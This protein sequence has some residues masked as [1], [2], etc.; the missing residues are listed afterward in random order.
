VTNSITPERPALHSTP[1]HA[2]LGELGRRI[3]RHFLLKTVGITGFMW[4]FFVAYFYLLRHP[5]R[6]VTV[7]PLTAL[8]SLVP[9][10]PAAVGAYL[11][12]WFYVGI[13]P[14]LV[15]TLRELLLHGVWAAALCGVGL[16]CFYFWPT[17]VPAAAMG[18]AGHPALALLQ[19]VDAAGN[20]CPSLHVA[21]AMFSAICLDALLRTVQ[22]P[23]AVRVASGLWFISIAYSTLAVRQHVAVDVLAGALLGALFALASLRWR[24][25]DLSHH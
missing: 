10:Q 8:D 5:A 11:S 21:T 15:W 12:L 14:G 13:V 22:V 3:R 1:G 16:A 4:L 23:L 20:A 25:R 17:A 7:M 6:P 24:T 2:W 18:V 19:G 9:F